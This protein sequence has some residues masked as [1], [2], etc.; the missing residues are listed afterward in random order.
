[1]RPAVIAGAALLAGFAACALVLSSDHMAD[2][3]VWA[4]FGPVVGWSFI[5]TGLY[6]SRRRPESRFGALMVLLGFT[7][8]LAPLGAADNPWLFAL[9]IVAGSLWGAVLAHVLLSFPSGRLT[10]AGQRAVVVAAYVIVPLAPVPGMLVSESEVL[11]DCDGPCPENPV[12]IS[13]DERLGE[14]LFAAGSAVVMTLCLLVVGLLIARW[15]AAGPSERRSLAPLLGAGAITLLLVFAYIATQ[16]PAFRT[17]AFVAFAVTPFAFLAGLARADVAQARGVRSLVAR[18]SDLPARADLRAALAATLG[19]PTLSLAYWVPEQGRYVDETGAPAPLP[20]DRAVTEVE[21]DGR[22]IAAIVHDGAVAQDETVRA[23]GAATALLLENQR[24]DAE[25]RA[26]MVEL[27]ASRA[28]LVQAGDDER[29]RLERNLHDGAQSRLVALAIHLRLGR[30]RLPD[31]SEAAKLIDASIDEL[32]QSL[33]ELRELARGIHPAV[34]SE[35]G[36]EPAL[37]ALAARSVVPVELVG[38]PGAPSR[39]RWRPR[40]TS[41]SSEALTNVAKYAQAGHATIRMER[42][43]GRLEL[44][45]SDDGVGGAVGDRRLRPARPV[46]S[47][48]RAGRR[49]G[50]QQPGG[51]R[52]A[53]ARPT[54]LRLMRVVV[55]EDSF[56][57]RAGVVRVLE[58]TGFTVVG[59]ASDADE[60]LAQVRRTPARRRRHRHPDAAHQH[61]R[62][63]A[64]R[65]RDPRRAAGHGSAR[66]LPARPPGLR[67][68][69]A[70][71]RRRRRRL[72]AQTARHGTSELRR[73]GPAGRARRLSARPGG[74]RADPGAP[75]PRR[76]RRQS[77][78]ARAGG[79]GADGRRPGAIATIAAELELSDATLER[80]QA[81]IFEKL[82][83]PS[84]VEGHR[85]VLAVLTYLRA[86]ED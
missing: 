80:V 23:A 40:R 85:R 54:S 30:N 28:R 48:R 41:S 14:I 19:D 38:T 12:L 11:A 62:G 82:E 65:G 68:P 35:R 84:D 39:P 22:R 49:A 44:E 51:R 5:G 76:P 58:E 4:V 56:L 73:G 47:R 57:M 59:E 36:L 13:D 45:V 42:V 70:R 8:L 10:G 21:R 72:S 66:S 69:T 25:L 67:R 43:N 15:R 50:A 29:R 2:R 3:V 18:L 20:S 81:R 9:G 71:R 86:Q 63:R 46:G 37:R 7:W 53:P 6:A 79:A 55:A 52:H 1:M 26:R 16:A 60:L 83:L 33:D 17:L 77:R 75:A 74:R 31:G 64:C 32:K 27:R 24:L 34:L 61:R 78:R